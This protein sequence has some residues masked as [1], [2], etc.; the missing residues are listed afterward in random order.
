MWE[1]FHITY[2]LILELI[3]V[4]DDCLSFPTGFCVLIYTV[5]LTFYSFNYTSLSL[6][7]FK[8][9]DLNNLTWIIFL[10]IS[11]TIIMWKAAQVN[12]EV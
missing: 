9:Q 2:S 11:L 8:M 1:K 6:T 12:Y 7:E 4:A 10:I 5:Q 3:N